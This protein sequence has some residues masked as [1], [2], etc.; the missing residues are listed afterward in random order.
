MCF[1]S[2]ICKVNHLYLRPIWSVKWKHTEQ[3]YIQSVS[4]CHR[5]IFLQDKPDKNMTIFTLIPACIDLWWP[6]TGCTVNMEE[7][8]KHPLML[9]TFTTVSVHKAYF[10]YRARRRRRT[11][12]TGH[13]NMLTL[14]HMR[15]TNNVT[16]VI[17]L[18][19]YRKYYCKRY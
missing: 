7:Y 15:K 12:A 11:S 16:E 4:L 2:Y 9:W 6:F 3:S 14:I 8:K 18:Y 1:I 10:R 13:T 5:V 19:G 17:A